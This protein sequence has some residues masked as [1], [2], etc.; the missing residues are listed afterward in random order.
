MSNLLASIKGKRPVV[1][2]IAVLLP[3]LTDHVVHQLASAERL[4][5]ILAKVIHDRPRVLQNFV[6][7]PLREPE[8]ARVM[9]IDASEKARPRRAANRN[10]AVSLRERDSAAASR[11]MFGV[12]A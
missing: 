8:A 9:R 5:S 11:A 1:G 10:I 4:V 7:V 3:L 2:M 6:T 12:L